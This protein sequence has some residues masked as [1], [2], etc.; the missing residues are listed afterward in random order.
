[1]QQNFVP[2]CVPLEDYARHGNGTILL[3]M[4]PGLYELQVRAYTTYGFGQFTTPPIIFE[5]EDEFTTGLL[6]I[7]IVVI[8][9]SLFVLVL[10]GAVYYYRHRRHMAMIKRALGD[11]V[12]EDPEFIQL[13]RP[14]KW[15]L[16]RCVYAVS[17]LTSA[18][19][20]T[21]LIWWHKL[22]MAHSALCI[23]VLARP[24]PRYVV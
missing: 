8:S 14:D 16:N 13:Y 6:W 21:T 2:V 7:T 19:A 24:S 18:H 3:N 15:E 23:A 10:F 12:E 9:G 4:H 22:A 20:V 17:A 5:I 1:M 11:W